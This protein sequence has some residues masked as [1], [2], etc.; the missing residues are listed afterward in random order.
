MT[1]LL[2]LPVKE[3][4]E[5]FGKGKGMT[6][7]G[8]TAALGALSATHILVSVCKLTVGKEQYTDVQQDIIALQKQLEQQHIPLLVRCID[9][10]ANVVRNMLRL[11]L[12]RDSATDD[13][14]KNELKQQAAAALK[15]AADMMLLLS[16]TCLEIIPG[17]LQLYNTG[18]KSARGDV[19]MAFSS[20]LSAASSG[21]Y[22][23]LKNIQA[24]KGAAW[25]T[26]R[27]S[28]VE[29][30]FGR[31]HEYQYIFNGR[32]ARLYNKTMF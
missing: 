2:D 4:L 14:E 1:T 8:A 20:L 10:D 22:A 7:A 30:C 13:N 27:R 29:T 15:P 17:A 3:L 9:G 5:E 31:L 11:R 16:N 26:D 28:Q 24:A 12:Q 18:L 23:A 32:L 19:A 25:T 21:L 6:G